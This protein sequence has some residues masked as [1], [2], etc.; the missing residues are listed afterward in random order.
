MR[1]LVEIYVNDVPAHVSI[2]ITSPS[3]VCGAC[4]HALTCANFLP[5]KYIIENPNLVHF[6]TY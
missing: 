5:R 3:C 4:A 6:H 1:I 2:L